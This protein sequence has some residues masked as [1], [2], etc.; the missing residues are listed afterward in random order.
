MI[1]ST[2]ESDFTSGVFVDER[3]APSDGGTGR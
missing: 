2:R 1:E 3:S